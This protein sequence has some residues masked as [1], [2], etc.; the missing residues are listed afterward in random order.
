MRCSNI[1]R[2]W[3]FFSLAP[4]G[5]GGRCCCCCSCCSVWHL[6]ACRHSPCTA[7]HQ[8]AVRAVHKEVELIVVAPFS[9][10]LL[11]PSSHFFFLLLFLSIAP[12]Y[13]LSL[14]PLQPVQYSDDAC[15]KEWSAKPRTVF[16]HSESGRRICT[17]SPGL[18]MQ[19]ASSFQPFLPIFLHR[20]WLQHRFSCSLFHIQ[21]SALN[22]YNINYGSIS[23]L[24][25]FRW[26]SG[27][28]SFTSNIKFSTNF[29]VMLSK[30]KESLSLKENQ[31]WKISFFHINS[32]TH[33]IVGLSVD[34]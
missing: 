24:Y 26:F 5:C 19:P 9:L 28:Q 25:Y 33:I 29:R 13:H 2:N 10:P 1:A 4:L 32:C 20:A 34:A 15:I 8:P 7:L 17:L 23:L 22:V 12:F 30:K 3:S 21:L 18:P 31:W 11:P 27:N 16:P 14:P 6:H